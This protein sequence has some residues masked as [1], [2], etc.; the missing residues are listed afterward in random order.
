M[1][2]DYVSIQF[3]LYII[4]RYIILLYIA[5]LASLRITNVGIKFKLK[6]FCLQLAGE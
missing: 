6:P 2:I 5:F 4:V 1:R 3:K